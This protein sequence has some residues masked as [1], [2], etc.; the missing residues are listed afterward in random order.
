MVNFG[1]IY[2]ISAFGLAQRLA[3]AR[4]EASEIIRAYF[5]EFPAVKGYMDRVVNECAGEGICGDDPGKTQ[6]ICAGY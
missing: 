6:E 4:G 3:I 1:I 5:E 2:G